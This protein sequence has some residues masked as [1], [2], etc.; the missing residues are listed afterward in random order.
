MPSPGPVFC[1]GAKANRWRTGGSGQVHQAAVVADIESTALNACR[2]LGKAELPRRS[3]APGSK[4]SV[5]AASRALRRQV[6]RKWR[7]RHR[8]RVRRR[9]FGRMRRNFGG[10][11]LRRPVRGD[12]KA[13]YRSTA[14]SRVVA[15]ARSAG[16][17][18]TTGAAAGDPE[19]RPVLVEHSAWGGAGRRGCG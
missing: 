8:G 10:P 17:V 4:P 13:D 16:A 12:A 6:P 9:A 2:C 14:G 18:Q 15:R 11:G 19:H 7:E 3:I 5:G 1:D